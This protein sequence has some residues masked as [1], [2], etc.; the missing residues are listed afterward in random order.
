VGVIVM[1]HLPMSLERY[2]ASVDEPAA[3]IGE[4]IKTQITA[5]AAEGYI[6]DDLKPANILVDPAHRIVKLIDFGSD[7]CAHVEDHTSDAAERAQVMLVLAR[8]FAWTF[9]RKDIFPD[10]TTLDDPRRIAALLFDSSVGT[11]HGSQMINY[12]V[13][14]NAHQMA[15]EAPATFVSFLQ[16]QR[17]LNSGNPLWR[18]DLWFY[19]RP[20]RPDDFP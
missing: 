12:A 13:A 15:G 2:L 17:Q 19:A 8:F 7:L 9:H 1:D 16:A 5:L 6:C 18:P 10:A 3:W 20:A 11:P 4:Q 14:G